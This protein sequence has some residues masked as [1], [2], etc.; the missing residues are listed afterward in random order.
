MFPPSGRR[1]SEG[2]V[3]AERH[4]PLAVAVQRCAP[5]LVVLVVAPALAVLLVNVECLRGSF[6]ER[7][8]QRFTCCSRKCGRL[9][10]KGTGHHCSGPNQKSSSSEHGCSPSVAHA[11]ESGT[12]CCLLQA[13][14]SSPP[15]PVKAGWRGR[16]PLWMRRVI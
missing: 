4:A 12:Y 10:H 6:G 13:T 5:L 3:G 9:F 2:L 1:R 15:L 7:Q 11:S 16:S 8:D 14:S